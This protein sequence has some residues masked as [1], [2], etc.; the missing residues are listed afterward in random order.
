MVEVEVAE[1][2]QM[3]EEVQTEHVAVLYLFQKLVG[4]NVIVF[5]YWLMGW[6]RRADGLPF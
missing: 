4:V 2:V 1:E 3:V 6:E 5:L